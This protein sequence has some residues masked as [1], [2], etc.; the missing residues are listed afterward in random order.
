MPRK[1]P[2]TKLGV[3]GKYDFN[4]EKAVELFFE[5]KLQNSFYIKKPAW[6][7]PRE[8]FELSGIQ[9]ERELFN[10]SRE[11]EEM[12][13]KATKASKINE[14]RILEINDVQESLRQQFVEVNDFIQ[15]CKAKEAEAQKNITEENEKQK[16]LKHDIEKLKKEVVELAEFE[17]SLQ[18]IVKKFQIYE[19]IINQVVKES[20]FFDNVDDLMAKCD[21]L[22]LA[23]VEISE[24]EQQKIK[25]V[26]DI[27]QQMVRATNNAAQIIL[28]L[29]NELDELERSYSTIKQES[30]KWEKILATTKDHISDNELITNRLLDSI[31]QLYRL[32]CKRNDV[33]SKFLRTNPEAQLDY[34]KDE[35]EMLQ[36]IS[37]LAHLKLH[38]ELKSSS[39]AEKGTKSKIKNAFLQK[40][41]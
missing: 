35:I 26:E 21:A 15:N 8:G 33:E 27:R 6:D 13:A 41:K 3:Y 23:Q 28:S 31:N 22:M 37:S 32:L 34:I 40:Y 36:K 20:D 9:N 16:V 25:S 38:K 29:D 10:V 18:E 39:V 17:T 19:D 2:T 4:P 12:R 11:Q 1:K 5:S 30:L 7:C 24:M 14:K